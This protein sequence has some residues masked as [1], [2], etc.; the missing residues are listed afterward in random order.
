[1][2]KKAFLLISLAALVFPCCKKIQ[3]SVEFT[4]TDCVSTK[5]AETKGLFGDGQVSELILEY[6][7]FGLAVTHL[8]AP[9]NCAFK[10][11]GLN[12]EAF[13]EG[14]VLHYWVTLPEGPVAN[15]TCL[16]GQMGSTVSGLDE[17]KE[18]ILD[19]VCEFTHLE[20][21][22]FT[23][24]KGFRRSIDVNRVGRIQSIEE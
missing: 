7:S 9:V 8:N 14:N 10:T 19:Y 2:K 22:S 16:L 4:F 17:G 1:M 20:P 21:I 13:L 11:T 23:Y 6:T 12:C 15:C 5:S 24:N 18:Y 3:H